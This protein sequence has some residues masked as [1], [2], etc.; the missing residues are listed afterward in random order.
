MPVNL[1]DENGNVVATTVTDAD[2]C[3]H[4]KDLLSGEYCTHY[5]NTSSYTADSSI[6]GSID[7]ST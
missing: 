5:E 1:T 4:F 2:G 7:P 6:P 3:Y